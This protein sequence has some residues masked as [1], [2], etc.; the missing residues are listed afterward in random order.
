MEEAILSHFFLKF[1]F[2][3]ILIKKSLGVAINTTMA[4][5]INYNTVRAAGSF[6][7]FSEAR[8]TGLYNGF[9]GGSVGTPDVLLR[10]FVDLP[11]EYGRGLLYVVVDVNGNVSFVPVHRATRVP[12]MPGVPSVLDGF[13]LGMIGDVGPLGAA[14]VEVCRV[15]SD[16]MHPFLGPVRVKTMGVLEAIVANG[17][18]RHMGPYDAAE[19]DTEEVGTVRGALVIPPDMLSPIL[20]RASWDIQS[21][22]TQIVKPVADGPNAAAHVELFNWFRVAATKTM[23]V[24]TATAVAAPVWT[25]MVN[26]IFR[27][28]EMVPMHALA[29]ARTFVIESCVY[30]DLPALNVSAGR[31]MDA[32]MIQELATGVTRMASSHEQ[33]H[34]E[35]VGRAAAATLRRE[36]E[37]ASKGKISTSKRT[38]HLARGLKVMFNLHTDVA[39]DTEAPAY[40]M[41]YAQGENK[42]DTDLLQLCYDTRANEADSATINRGAGP[43]AT[44]SRVQMARQAR[45]GSGAVHE[46]LGEGFTLWT[47]KSS[48][49]EEGRLARIQAQIASDSEMGTVNLSHREL[50]DLTAHDGV[51]WPTNVPSLLDR[52]RCYSIEVDVLLGVNHPV[53]TELRRTAMMFGDFRDQLEKRYGDT[54]KGLG[55]FIRMCLYIHVVMLRYFN[56]VSMGIMGGDDAKLPEMHA[57]LHDMLDMNNFNLLPPIPARYVAKYGAPAL[58]TAETAA[59]QAPG[60]GAAGT[61]ATRVGGSAT[62]VGP[63]TKVENPSVNATLK[64]RFERSGCPTLKALLDKNTT[65]VPLPLAGNGGTVC[66]SWMLRGSCYANCKRKAV[67]GSANATTVQ[68]V[69][70]FLTAIGVAE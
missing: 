28:R 42:T 53:A 17:G 20:Q 6:G 8:T 60:T 49:E 44:K 24:A 31:T 3:S 54:D 64:T 10:N 37:A 63:G 51:S 69:H 1:G 7:S 27:G 45:F 25:P 11:V 16:A 32:Q 2:D 9:G 61:S 68:G 23:S 38:T 26:L 59:G 29:P 70:G 18:G 33:A 48:G 36:T 67:H 15:T 52:L 21:F 14:S 62:V 35:A 65:G 47:T 55:V 46:N 19:A 40:W 58:A 22:Y 5:P 66:F 41:T 4:Q 12:V 30:T 34:Q 57:K 50:M 13:V 56:G 43:I 39:L